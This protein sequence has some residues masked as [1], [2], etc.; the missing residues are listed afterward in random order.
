MDTADTT[1]MTDIE[2]LK[3][4]DLWP[5]WPLLPVKRTRWE[6]G[7]LVED[8]E[9]N[10]AFPAV[11]DPIVGVVLHQYDSLEALVADGW[12]ID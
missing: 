9:T 12:V 5:R 7:A 6:T 4:A 2:F 10:V 3:R 8:G 11:Y 1:E